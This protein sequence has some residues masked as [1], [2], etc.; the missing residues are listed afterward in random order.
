MQ[1]LKG[2]WKIVCLF[3]FLSCQNEWKNKLEK[4]IYQFYKQNYYVNYN[5]IYNQCNDSIDYWMA[6]SLDLAKYLI[7]DTNFTLD[8]VLIFNQDST[9]LFTTLNVK[10]VNNKNAE[11]D[12]IYELGG[13]KIHGKWYFFFG[14]SLVVPRE[15]FSDKLY[16][17]LSFKRLSQIAH[18]QYH[19]KYITF[20]SDGNYVVNEKLFDNYLCPLPHG[21]WEEK[22]KVVVDSMIIADL[23]EQRKM[24]LDLKE[25]A[26]IKAEMAA[27]KQPLE[28]RRW[29]IWF[30]PYLKSDLEKPRYPNDEK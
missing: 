13:A 4:D 3:F 22:P 1:L 28:P 10:I 30:G 24:K 9:R 29:F 5:N 18:E 6:D 19:A 23:A 21:S 2:N 12:Y 11:V 7:T 16:E 25:V 14:A 8:S 15:M 26:Q 17:P 20:Y 27:S